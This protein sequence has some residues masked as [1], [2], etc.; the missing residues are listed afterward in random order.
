MELLQAAHYH[1][2]ALAGEARAS[3]TRDRY[4]QIEGAFIRYVSADRGQP[5]TLADLTVTTVR[6]F[7]VWAAE[8]PATLAGGREATRGPATLAL[9]ATVLRAWSRL[10]AREWPELFAKGDPLANLR[11]PHVPSQ[12]VEVLSRQ[13]F[14]LL[15]AHAAITQRPLRDRALLLF[16]ADTGIRLSELCALTTERLELAGGQHSGRA[17]IESG[18]GGKSRF[19]YFG[20]LTSKA[21]YRYLQLERARHPRPVAQLFLGRTGE[22]ICPDT[23]QKLLTSLGK[24]A[25]I[26][27][28]RCSPHTLRHTFATW[29]LQANPGQLEQLRQLLGHADLKMVLVYAKLTDADVAEQY[30]SPVDAFQRGTAVRRAG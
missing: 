29:F 21:L 17:R 15:V 8:T 19:V 12:P 5:A 14:D 26:R 25:G 4:A 1:A 11:I 20:A 18:K 9:Y 3:S 6:R 28:V 23:I 10:L 24:Q 16:L 30:R 2:Q 13:Q 7:L 27:N 22:G